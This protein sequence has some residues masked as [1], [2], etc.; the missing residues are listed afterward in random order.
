MARSPGT[1]SRSTTRVCEAVDL[2]DDFNPLLHSPGDRGAGQKDVVLAIPVRRIGKNAYAEVAD[3]TNR[4]RG[5]ADQARDVEVHRI[6]AEPAFV[7]RGRQLR[8]KPDSESGMPWSF[9]D[10]TNLRSD[11][12]VL[13]VIRRIARDIQQARQRRRPTQGDVEMLET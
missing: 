1:G 7:A 8:R 5:L 2:S 13:D 12:D 3:K 4:L 10:E 6:E 9:G 11:D